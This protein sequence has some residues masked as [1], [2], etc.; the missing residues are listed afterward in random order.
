M[1]IYQKRFR[2]LM[3][4]VADWPPFVSP[5]RNRMEEIASLI[6]GDLA[7]NTARVRQAVLSASRYST[8][9]QETVE[10]ALYW[11]LSTGEPFENWPM[12]A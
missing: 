8:V 2:R 6:P 11:H 7:V 9:K 10:R 3:V 5:W 1:D 4:E 12:P